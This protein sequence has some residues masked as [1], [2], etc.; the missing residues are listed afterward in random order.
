MTDYEILYNTL[1]SS[2]EAGDERAKLALALV[3]DGTPSTAITDKIVQQLGVINASVS[4]I[5][6]VSYLSAACFEARRIQESAH[7]IAV[8]INQL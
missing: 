6:A 1:K 8:L 2:A 4:S 3:S 7:N 5:H